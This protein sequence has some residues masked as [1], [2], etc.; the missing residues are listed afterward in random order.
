MSARPF[1]SPGSRLEA[2][3]RNATTRPFADSA[4]DSVNPLAG[5]PSDEID[6]RLIPAPRRH[7]K[8]PPPSVRSP[9][10]RFDATEEKAIADPSTEIDG[11]QLLPSASVIVV[12]EPLATSLVVGALR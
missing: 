9:A 1:V 4:G 5:F 3:E 10:T 6:T 8:I 2:R 11:C 7:R 12:R